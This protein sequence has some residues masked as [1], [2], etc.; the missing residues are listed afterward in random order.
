VQARR[1]VDALCLSGFEVDH[2]FERGRL[3]HRQV[4]G[5]GPFED[6][7]DVD[8][9][10]TIRVRNVG[11]IADQA[12]DIGELAKRMNRHQAGARSIRSMIWRA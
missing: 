2:Q 10:L 3:K 4:G 12:A 5:V 6:A 8:A 7:A 1:N 11:A 9:D